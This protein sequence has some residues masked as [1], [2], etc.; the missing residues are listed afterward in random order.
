[1][2]SPSTP[3]GRGGPNDDEQGDQWWANPFNP[4][5]PI[6]GLY[7]DP[8]GQLLLGLLPTPPASASYISSQSGTNL[9]YVGTLMNSTPSMYQ[10]FGYFEVGV[11]VDNLPGFAFQ[12]CLESWEISHSWPP[13]IDIRIQ[14]D[15]SGNQSVLLEVDTTSG[16]IPTTIAMDATG[17]HA[18]GIDWESDFITFYIDRN[19][20]FQ[21]PTPTDGTYTSYPA[22]WYLLT[23]ANYINLGVDPD[24]GS[25]PVYAHV[26][27]VTAWASRPF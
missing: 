10:L 6:Q 12:A 7:T 25:L 11:A 22:Y 14:T 23:G 21:V 8:G 27:S 24:P 2:I 16:G 18:Y 17:M 19:Q 4:A 5:T 26:G 20:V 1:L 9:P 13:E 3:D 15:G